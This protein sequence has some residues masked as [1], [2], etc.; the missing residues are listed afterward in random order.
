MMAELEHSYETL[1]ELIKGRR[2][3]GSKR[4]SSLAV[5]CAELVIRRSESER[6]SWSNGAELNEII[7]HPNFTMASKSERPE[8]LMRSARAKY[9]S[10]IH[11]SWDHY[12]GVDL[13]PLLA[14]KRVMDLGC[15]F[16]GRSVA[17][18][19][20]YRIEHMTG[21]DVHPAYIEAAT[22]FAQSRNVK[23][24]FHLAV[25]ER[26]PFEAGTFHAILSFDV[27]E[28]VQSVAA[29]LI[30]CHRVLRP[31]GHLCVVFPSYWQPLEHHLSLVTRVPGLQYMF[32]GHTLVAAYNQILDSRGVD[33]AWYK[34]QKPELQPWERCNTINGT[35]LR[36][37]RR[38]IKEGGWQIVKHSRPPIGS[39]GRTV[40]NRPRPWHRALA[41][42]G[43]ALVEIP[44][45]NEAFLH[46][47]VFIL[48]RD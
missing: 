13:A 26:L 10:E 14:G 12:F 28:H 5:R 45:V 39:M 21:I 46:R 29:T 16:G 8:L 7:R 27:Y 41:A 37:F 30:E 43:R 3:G 1:L 17:W 25:G 18:A 42:V 19:E 11:Y 47:I 36:S 22:R 31:G 15:L 23:A 33:A 40:V 2:H 38:L 9:E 34:R 20:R 24:D 35:T 6:P 48:R 32:S 4:M 44:V